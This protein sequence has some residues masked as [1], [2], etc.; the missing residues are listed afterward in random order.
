[1]VQNLYDSSSS[2]TTNWQ[3]VTEM[4]REWDSGGE[5]WVT[6]QTPANIA[7]CTSHLNHLS[8]GEWIERDRQ[9]QHYISTIYYSTTIFYLLVSTWLLLCAITDG[10]C[11][12]EGWQKY[13]YISSPDCAD[14]MITNNTTLSICVGRSCLNSFLKAYLTLIPCRDKINGL[15]IWI[16]KRLWTHSTTVQQ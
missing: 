1:M 14:Y 5:H 15:T 6:I 10:F 7:A 2:T 9:Q 16:L 12:R 8:C 3:I 4:R 11:L 13:F